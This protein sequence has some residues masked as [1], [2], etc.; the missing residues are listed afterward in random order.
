MLRRL[1]KSSFAR[2]SVLSLI[3]RV[4]GIGA[5]F[6]MHVM[7]AHSL[8]TALAGRFLV[9]LAVVNILAVICRMGHDT[10]LVRFVAANTATGDVD[11]ARSA[12]RIALERTGQASLCVAGILALVILILHGF[13][14]PPMLVMCF[15]VPGT[16]LAVVNS[17]ALRGRGHLRQALFLHPLCIPALSSLGLAL[18]FQLGSL[19]AVAVV[20]LISASVA[21]SIGVLLCGRQINGGKSVLVGEAREFDRDL[22]WRTSVPLMWV[23]S[24][25][26]IGAWLGTLLLGM[27]GSGQEDV[28]RFNMASKAAQLAALALMAINTVI[29]PRMAALHATGKQ[30]HLQRIAS[31]GTAASVLFSFPY[32]L[33][34]V[35]V[36]D[37][38]MSVFGPN[39]A[40]AAGL[41]PV[42]AVGQL[43]NTVTGPA[44]QALSMCGFERLVQRAWMISLS[45]NVI[46][47]VAAI[48]IYGALGA[49]WA[50]AAGLI[51]QNVLSFHY[52]KSR[53]GINTLD[54]RALLA[55]KDLLR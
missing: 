33:A 9:M 50:S 12:Y 16:C 22:L 11:L 4:V 23:S 54:V 8:D 2:A 43:V 38:L 18:V 35:T 53:A 7:L 52:S 37:L 51:V 15:A 17:E 28:A 55:S 32:L 39:Y 21:A 48:P 26:M 6:G 20:Y 40:S 24:L 49:A 29:M 27:L 42:L 10:A 46:V 19:L 13:N 47:S 1:T 45:V 14:N 36:P 25:N 5:T 34:M 41:L 31:V 30:V 3:L 44:G